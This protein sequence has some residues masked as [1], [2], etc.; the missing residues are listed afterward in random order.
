MNKFAAGIIAGGVLSMV[1]V[2]C[3]LNDGKMKR[4]MIKTGHKA[5]DK[6]E[7]LINEVEDML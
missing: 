1:G 2:V 7:E 3:L 4:K 6:A 5:V